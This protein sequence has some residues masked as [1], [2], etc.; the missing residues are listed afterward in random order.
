M[1][2]LYRGSSIDASYQVSF[3]LAKGFQRRMSKCEN[4]ITIY[5]PSLASTSMFSLGGCCIILRGESSSSSLST[6]G[7]DSEEELDSPRKIIQQPPSENMDVDA[8]DG[9]YI[10]IPTLLTLCRQ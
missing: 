10:V 4:E 7:I 8:N 5:L 9:K 6:E 3:H 2:I 1:S